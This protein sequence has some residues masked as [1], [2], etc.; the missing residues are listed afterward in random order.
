VDADELDELYEELT[1]KIA[2]QKVSD[3]RWKTMDG[4]VLLMKDMAD[5]H[6]ENAIL[7]LERRGV[8][9]VGIS[10][11]LGGRPPSSDDEIAAVV[12]AHHCPATQ[13][14]YEAYLCLL[15]EREWRKK[16]CGFDPVGP[17]KNTVLR[18]PK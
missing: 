18:T 8:L 2:I 11:R 10:V 4:R 7:Y 1:G 16:T 5:S 15:S 3:R 14:S 13:G 17:T 9:S 6:L 12:E